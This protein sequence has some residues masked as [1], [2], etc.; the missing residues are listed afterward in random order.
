MREHHHKNGWALALLGLSASLAVAC[1]DPSQVGQVNVTQTQCKQWDD[2]MVALFHVA[3]VASAAVPLVLA[4][5]LGVLGRGFWFFTAPR[6]RIVV[7]SGVIVLVAI[8][9]VPA[10]PWVVGLGWGWLSNVDPLYF[11]CTSQGF[12]AEGLLYGLI[13]PGQAA[14]SQWPVMILLLI[15]G[16]IVGC[17]VAILIQA[18]LA[19]LFGIRRKLKGGEE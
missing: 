14:L 19:R 15:A 16:A 13:S 3:L 12:G 6:R 11:A 10:G 4:P 9:A 18:L 5:F 8:L 7:L 2:A 1:Q 17:L